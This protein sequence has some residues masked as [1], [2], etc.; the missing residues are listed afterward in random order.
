M[1]HRVVYAPRSRRDLEK[2]RAYLA[3]ES[4]NPATADRFLTKLFEHCEALKTF[5][6]RYAIYPYAR[7]WRMMP[8]EDYLVFFDV[9]ESLVRIAHIRH[10]ARKPFPGG[11][12]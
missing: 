11:R 9:H 7:S 8:F 5:P 6:T 10:G 1:T 3:T 12:G 2:I 4:G